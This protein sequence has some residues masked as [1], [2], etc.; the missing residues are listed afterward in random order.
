MKKQVLGFT[1]EVQMRELKLVVLGIYSKI[2][3]DVQRVLNH[4]LFQHQ[5]DLYSFYPVKNVACCISLTAS[6]KVALC[7]SSFLGKIHTDNAL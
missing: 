7:I 6:F 3:L 5:W 1:S 2:L 4:R